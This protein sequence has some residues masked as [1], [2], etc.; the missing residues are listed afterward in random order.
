MAVSLASWD[1]VDRVLEVLDDSQALQG[2]VGQGAALVGTPKTLLATS[3]SVA[4]ST[5]QATNQQ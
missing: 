1:E 5:A 4:L 3:A 2:A